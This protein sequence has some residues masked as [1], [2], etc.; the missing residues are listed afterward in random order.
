M[1]APTSAAISGGTGND[2]LVGG[3]GNDT[4]NG[5][6]GTDTLVGGGGADVLNGGNGSDTVDYRRAAPTCR[7]PSTAWP[8]TATRRSP[9]TT[10]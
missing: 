1:L 4:L 6:A 8:T 5:Q 9:R 2:T 10:T 7:C 3:D